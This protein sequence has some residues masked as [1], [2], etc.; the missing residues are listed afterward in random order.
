MK[1]VS[2]TVPTWQLISGHTQERGHTGVKYAERPLSPQALW[3]DTRRSTL[4][5]NILCV[6]TVG[7]LLNGWSLLADT[8]GVFTKGRICLYDS[9][10]G[11]WNYTCPVDLICYFM[12]VKCDF[13]IS[14]P[15]SVNKE[16]NVY[17]WIML[18]TVL[19]PHSALCTETLAALNPVQISCKNTITD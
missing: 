5:G 6:I 13:I 9:A 7:S 4:K 15:V 8:W 2:V 16:C 3:T 17:L 14:R 10:V 19:G 1:S 12:S 18:A 11:H